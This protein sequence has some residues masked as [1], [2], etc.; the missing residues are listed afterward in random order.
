MGPLGFIAAFVP[1]WLMVVWLIGRIGGWHRC[2][3]AYGGAGE[4][5]GECFRM[6]TVRFGL[7]NYKGTVNMR[8][9]DGGIEFS[10]LALFR[11]GHPTFFV[12][13]EDITV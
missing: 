4:T 6:Q 5:T 7:G 3:E 1:F 9:G 2:A 8:L 13:W 12:P 11:F 10:V